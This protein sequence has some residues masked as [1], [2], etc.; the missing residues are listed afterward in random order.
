VHSSIVFKIYAYTESKNLPRN[1]ALLNPKSF[2]HSPFGK[3][4]IVKQLL[5]F[6][7][8]QLVL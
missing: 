4:T 2:A 6:R 1:R 7:A 5:K 3:I 8:M